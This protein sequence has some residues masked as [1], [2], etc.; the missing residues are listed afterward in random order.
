[1]PREH[2]THTV[3]TSPIL[4]Q[5]LLNEGHHSPLRPTAGALIPDLLFVPGS[6]LLSGKAGSRTP[7]IRHG[8]RDVDC[9]HGGS[10]SPCA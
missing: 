6:G 9:D 5:T 10:F 1:M 3:A 8:G 7:P 4:G 2:L